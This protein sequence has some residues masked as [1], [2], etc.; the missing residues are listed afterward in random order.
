MVRLIALLA[1]FCI[2]PCICSRMCFLSFRSFEF[3]FAHVAWRITC[4]TA[5]RHPGQI[6]ILGVATW[7]QPAS[8]HL[9]TCSQLASS[10]RMSSRLQPRRSH[11]EP[12]HAKG[13]TK[14]D[15]CAPPS[16]V[17]RVAVAVQQWLDHAHARSSLVTWQPPL[18]LSHTPEN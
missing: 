5:V 7:P 2:P 6:F 15:K 3:A 8:F 17:L 12:D 11:G 4:R 18:F 13:D 14:G 9:A 1:S 16:A 10:R